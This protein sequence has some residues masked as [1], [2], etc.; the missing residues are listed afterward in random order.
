MEADSFLGPLM[1]V[2]MFGCQPGSVKLHCTVNDGV[3]LCVV[4]DTLMSV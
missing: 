4:P 2:G 3:Y 1:L